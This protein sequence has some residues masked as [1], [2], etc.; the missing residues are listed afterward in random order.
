LY[1]YPRISN[2]KETPDLFKHP[3]VHLIDAPIVEISATFI[4]KSIA[5]KKNIRALL[6]DKAWKYLDEMNFYK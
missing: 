6:P 5:G 2:K 1:I 3:K 4:R